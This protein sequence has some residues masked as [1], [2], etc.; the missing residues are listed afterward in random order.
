LAIKVIKGHVRRNGLRYG[1]GEIITGLSEN[2][3]S[4]IVSEGF[5]EYVLN[6]SELEESEVEESEKEEPSDNDTTKKPLEE[7]TSENYGTAAEDNL[8][9]I[10][11]KFDPGEYVQ[12]AKNKRD[13]K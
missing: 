7:D 2:E 9:N 3:E 1:M 13:R 12:S 5:A 8:D 4:R 6:V 10:E 11:I